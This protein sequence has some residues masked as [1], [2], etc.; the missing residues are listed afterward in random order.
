[1][2]MIRKDPPLD[3]T[4]GLRDEEKVGR[5]HQPA[6][7]LNQL[8]RVQ[9]GLPQGLNLDRCLPVILLLQRNLCR[10]P[11]R[12]RNPHIRCL[13]QVEKI[14]LLFKLLSILNG[15]PSQGNHQHRIMIRTKLC[16]PFKETLKLE[17]HLEEVY[18]ATTDQLDWV[19]PEGQ[20][21]PHNLLQPF[22]LIPNNRGR[23]VIPFEHFIN[24]ELEYLWG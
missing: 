5:M 1:M 16:Q 18:K 17:Y 8:P 19:N 7:H 3:Q 24:N 2:M 20:Q 10:L 4:G 21:Y 13:K 9:E 6:L 11:V 22:P 12:W 15:S 23:R 14:N